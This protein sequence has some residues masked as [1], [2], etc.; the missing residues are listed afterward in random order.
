MNW[1]KAWRNTKSFV[2]RHRVGIAAGLAGVGCGVIS[3]GVAGAF[4]AAGVGMIAG[5]AAKKLGNRK[6]SWGSV[7]RAAIYGGGVAA[8]GWG[9]SAGARYGAAGPWSD[10]SRAAANTPQVALRTANHGRGVGNHPL[11]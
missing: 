4:C 7:G 2:K 11:M 6:A 10:G 3:M 1:K 9:L 8:T 5:G